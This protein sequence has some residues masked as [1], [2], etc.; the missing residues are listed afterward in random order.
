MRAALGA[1]AWRDGW[2]AQ[3]S[4][5][6]PIAIVAALAAPRPQPALEAQRWLAP[7]PLSNPPRPHPS[8]CPRRWPPTRATCP[9]A[10]R[11]CLGEASTRAAW[12]RWR[13]RSSTLARSCWWSTG[14]ARAARRALRGDALRRCPCCALALTRSCGPSRLAPMHALQ[15]G[16]DLEEHPEA[17]IL[18]GQ[19]PEAQALPA[20][21]AGAPAAGEEGDAPVP[22]KAQAAYRESEDGV[23]LLDSEDE[24]PAQAQGAWGG[25]VQGAGGGGRWI[26]AGR[27]PLLCMLARRLATLPFLFCS[28][29]S[30]QARRGGGGRGRRRQARAAGR[31]SSGRRVVPP[32]VSGHRSVG[33]LSGGCVELCTLMRGV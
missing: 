24:Q 10:W 13:T 16:L 20:A 26:G 31:A 5:Q 8:L 9:R 12:W 18:S 3:Q 25:S 30:R 27:W 22:A 4:I 17:Y 19:L 11:R 2:P 7:L 32:W 6:P 28:G 33:R 23:L 15:P 21:Q 14:C 29:T 1:N